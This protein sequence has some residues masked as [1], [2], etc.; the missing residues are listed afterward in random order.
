MKYTKPPLN[1]CQ[2]AALLI[3]RGLI[4]DQDELE[5]FLGRANYYRFSGYLFPYRAEDGEN[6]QE[7]TT[8]HE[9]RNIYEFDSELR[10][11][12]LSAIEIIDIAILRTRL[13]EKFTLACGPFCYRNQSS[14][15]SSMSSY[16]HQ[17]VLEN[18]QQSIERSDEIFVQK[19]TK[20]YTS[21]KYLPFWMVAEICSMSQMSII[22]KHLPYSI[23]APIAKDIG[24]HSNDLASWLHTLTVI[25][26]ICAHHARLWNRILPVRPKFP[27]KKHRPEFYDPERIPN[28]SFFM[29]LAILRY[30]IQRINPEVD[31][32]DE[33]YA[34]LE[35]HSGIPMF[36]MGFPED[37]QAYQV[38]K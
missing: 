11:M 5:E 4:V 23:Q 37:W 7:G 34:L 2:Q 3:E 35:K 31:V 25:R 26:N 38:F 33:F 9:I 8:F 1:F 13:V 17:K 32:L 18:I 6:F 19:Y 36:R 29:V 24:L 15:D 10:S 27:K 22:F 20:K 12:T 28:H 21:E 16:Y 30:L 14:F